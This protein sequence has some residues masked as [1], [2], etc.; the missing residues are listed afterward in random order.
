MKDIIIY[1]FYYK[2]ISYIIIDVNVSNLALN[3]FIGG[4]Y[5]KKDKQFYWKLFISTFSLSAFTFGGGFVIIPL[6][7]KKFVEKL[8]WI[9][10][11]EM[12]N[13]TAIAQSA[14]GAIAA[15]ASILIGYHLCGV[16]G[17]L[18]TILGTVLPPLI[19]MSVISLFYTTFK[20]NIIANALL[21][22]MQA[23]VAAVIF[24]VVI[25]MGKSIVKDKKILPIL[26]ML[27]AFIATYFFKVNVMF[28]ILV[29]GTIGGFST[30]YYKRA[31]KEC[32]Q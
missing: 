5:M 1:Y 26:L 8:K 21:R 19:I 10:E 22:G 15:N 17:S 20:N 12:I 16:L 7:R 2:S 18:I 9:D 24:D 14:P 28:I 25:S 30:I 23:G 13:L 6:L 11:E 32:S 27:C 3:M 29:C 31:S 4:Y